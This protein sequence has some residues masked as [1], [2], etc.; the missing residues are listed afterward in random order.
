METWTYF[1]NEER[2]LA[3]ETADAMDNQKRPPKHF[4]SDARYIGMLGEIAYGKESGQ[5]VNCELMIMGDGGTDFPGGVDVKTST[6]VSDPHLKHYAN[7]NHWPEWFVLVVVPR[8]YDKYRIAGHASKAQMLAAD[9]ADYGY[10]DQYYIPE[11]WLT[12]GLP[13]LTVA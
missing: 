13:V 4:N 11:Y 6:F 1:T 8:S 5:E 9:I 3:R 7:P 2:Q 10:G 12:P